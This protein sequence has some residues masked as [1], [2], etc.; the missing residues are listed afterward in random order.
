[1]NEIESQIEVNVGDIVL[2]EKYSQGA[3]VVTG[4][5]PLVNVMFLMEEDGDKYL[6]PGGTLTGR[7]LKLGSMALDEVV[8][9]WANYY[10]KNGLKFGEDRKEELLNRLTEEQ[11]KGPVLRPLWPEDKSS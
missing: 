4:V 6:A 2:G 9:G 1:M 3:A 8:D 11:L 7:L 5:L 10:H